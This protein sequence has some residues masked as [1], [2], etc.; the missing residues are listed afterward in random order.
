MGRLALS[1]LVGLLD[2]GFAS[3]AD[4]AVF[5]TAQD[6]RWLATGRCTS[7]HETEQKASP[8]L[9]RLQVETLQ[10]QYVPR[11]SIGFLQ[12]LQ[13]RHWLPVST[14]RPFCTRE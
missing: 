10:T 4:G 2:S 13:R 1:G 6:W 8:V 5:S 7:Q 11:Y 9:L 3:E 12:A 14:T